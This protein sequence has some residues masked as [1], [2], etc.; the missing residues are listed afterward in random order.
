MVTC[1]SFTSLTQREGGTVQYGYVLFVILFV[2][3][4]IVLFIVL[5][6]GCRFALPVLRMGRF[7][8]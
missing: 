6:Y 5:G 7:C 3:L 2:I 8:S 1:F 4:F